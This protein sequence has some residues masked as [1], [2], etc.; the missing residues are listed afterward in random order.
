MKRIYRCGL[1]IRFLYWDTRL[2]GTMEKV[3]TDNGEKI[4]FMANKGEYIDDLFG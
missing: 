2:D 4:N 3:Y 1:Y